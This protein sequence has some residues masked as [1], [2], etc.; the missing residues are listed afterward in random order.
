MPTRT[1]GDTTHETKLAAADIGYAQSTGTAGHRTARPVVW[2]DGGCNPAP[3]RLC[4]AWLTAL[5]WKSSD[6]HFAVID[7]DPSRGAFGASR[8]PTSLKATLSWFFCRLSLIKS[9]RLLASSCRLAFSRPGDLRRP[10]LTSAARS[11]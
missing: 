2:E 1:P 9:C 7:S 3:T 4:R 5:G 11:E 10:L 6:I 8:R